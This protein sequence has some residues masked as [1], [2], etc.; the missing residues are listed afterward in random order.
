MS[1]PYTCS[2]SISSL[3]FPLSYLFYIYFTNKMETF[4]FLYLH[5]PT[6][7]P[8]LFLL[9]GVFSCLPPLK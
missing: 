8:P 4:S 3:L 5:C 7:F 9:L 1:F 2:F 6:L